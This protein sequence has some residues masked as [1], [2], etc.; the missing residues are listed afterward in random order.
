MN[1][2]KN[3]TNVAHAD[4]TNILLN[5]RIIINGLPLT[6]NELGV[7]VR[8][9]QMLYEKASQLDASRDAAKAE[10]PKDPEKK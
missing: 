2:V 1:P 10:K 7:I 6:G 4:L 3:P 5:G 9:E 8:G